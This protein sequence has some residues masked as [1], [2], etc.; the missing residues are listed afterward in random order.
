[1]RKSRQTASTKHIISS[2][3]LS[4]FFWQ[5]GCA[6]LNCLRTDTHIVIADIADAAGRIDVFVHFY[7]NNRATEKLTDPQKTLDFLNLALNRSIFD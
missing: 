7:S 5:R 2:R 3:L 6:R 4:A 1:M